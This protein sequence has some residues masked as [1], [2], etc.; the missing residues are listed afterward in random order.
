MAR[1]RRSYQLH[2]V[3]SKSDRLLGFLEKLETRWQLKPVKSPE[4]AKP[5]ESQSPGSPELPKSALTADTVTTEIPPKAPVV[6]MRSTPGKVEVILCRHLSDIIMRADTK[7]PYGLHLISERKELIPLGRALYTQIVAQV[8]PGT[9]RRIHLDTLLRKVR[10]VFP[11][12]TQRSAALKI[13]TTD[14]LTKQKWSIEREGR[15]EN[16]YL[17]VI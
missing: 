12:T 17:R 6:T 7:T 1:R 16:V 11:T 4:S 13:L 14:W 10:N 15:A 3:L 5:V 9:E 2:L 8:R